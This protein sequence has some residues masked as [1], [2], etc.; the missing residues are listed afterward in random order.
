MQV[1]RCEWCG[2]PFS[3]EVGGRGQ[4]AKYCDEVFDHKLERP[5]GKVVQKSCSEAAGAWRLVQSW[6]ESQL[7]EL[8]GDAEALD[9]LLHHRERIMSTRSRI[10]HPKTGRL[11]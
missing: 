3:V 10:R 9:A 2:R 5:K 6:V 4:P 7:G 8:E 11:L 1:C